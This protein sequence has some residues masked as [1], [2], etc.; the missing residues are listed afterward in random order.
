M[1]RHIPQAIK[2]ENLNP[3]I[4][5][6]PVRQ[7]IVASYP[8]V[9]KT[10]GSSADAPQSRLRCSSPTQ[11]V[12]SLVRAFARTQ[13]PRGRRRSSSSP[14]VATDPGSNGT[15]FVGLQGRQ[16]LTVEVPRCFGVELVDPLR[17]ERHN[18][19]ASPTRTTIGSQVMTPNEIWMEFFRI[20]CGI[21]P[22]NPLA[23]PEVIRELCRIVRHLESG[24][25]SERSRRRP[26]K[27]AESFSRYLALPGVPNAEIRPT[28][29]RRWWS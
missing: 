6:T 9:V 14:S 1:L 23:Y 11:V 13:R 22:S 27:R 29:A 26:L 28:P 25:V 24:I 12:R 17:Q 7:P 21:I 4:I 2:P 20:F 5:A 8:R 18:V 15:R 10:N 19:E 3:K 16:G